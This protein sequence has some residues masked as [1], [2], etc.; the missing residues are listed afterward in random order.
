MKIRH[1]NK[2]THKIKVRMARRMLSQA[3]IKSGCPIFA[4][5][6]WNARLTARAIK[7]AKRTKVF[8]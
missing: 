8:A 2:V 6:A 1:K 3:E 5:Q 4:S 7:H